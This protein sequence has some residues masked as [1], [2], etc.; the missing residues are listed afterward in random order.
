MKKIS[1]LVIAVSL[2]LMAVSCGGRKD[3]C[4]SV[5]YKINTSPLITN[6]LK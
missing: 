5:G 6:T 4:P 3:R 1:T 2:I